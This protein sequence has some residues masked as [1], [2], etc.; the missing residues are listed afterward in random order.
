ML[1]RDPTNYISY[2][3]ST[4]LT[5]DVIGEWVH[6]VCSLWCVTCLYMSIPAPTHS[7]YPTTPTPPRTPE[8]HS[9]HEEDPLGQGGRLLSLRKLDTARDKTLR[10]VFAGIGHLSFI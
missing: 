7:H 3:Y 10:C 8:L 1:T 4:P 9:L 2:P 6:P 5:A